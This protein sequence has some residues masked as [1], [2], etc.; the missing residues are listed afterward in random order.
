MTVRG[1]LALLKL[2]HL[3]LS[4]FGYMKK[5]VILGVNWKSKH[6]Q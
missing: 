6:D 5:L 1:L 3:K 4:G 2:S